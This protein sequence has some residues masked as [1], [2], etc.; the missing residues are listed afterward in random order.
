M[1]TSAELAAMKAGASSLEDL[2]T[3]M[4]AVL[5]QLRTDVEMTQSAWAGTAQIAFR[6]VMTRWD[7]SSAKLNNAINEISSLLAGNT[8]S[9]GTTEAQSEADLQSVGGA[10]LNM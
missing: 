7:E 2:G 8:T 6:T 10:T 4:N 5:S 9:Y 1:G 3:Q